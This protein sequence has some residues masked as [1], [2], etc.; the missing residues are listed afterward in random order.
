MKTIEPDSCPV[1]E[2]CRGCIHK[3]KQRCSVITEPIYFW[4]KY[5][6]CLFKAI[7]F[8]IPIGSYK[9]NPLSW[10]QKVKELRA[11]GLIP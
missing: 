4:E 11:H 6:R 2:M 10:Q 3:G 1:D 5:R 7:V 8:S 9:P